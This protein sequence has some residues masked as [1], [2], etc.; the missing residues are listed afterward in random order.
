MIIKNKEEEYIYINKIIKLE[1]P[2]N[3]LSRSQQDILL[4]KKPNLRF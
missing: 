2:C 1:V 4:M 3:L